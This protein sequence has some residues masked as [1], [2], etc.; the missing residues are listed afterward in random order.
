MYGLLGPNGAGKSI[1][2][3]SIAGDLSS[4]GLI[5][6]HGKALNLWSAK[7]KARHIAVLTQNHSL[8]FPFTAKEVVAF[9]LFPLTLSKKEADE[10]ITEYMHQTDTLSLEKRLYPSLSGGEQQ[11]IQ[12]ARVLL[13]LHQATKPP[14]LL[15]DEIT[16]A[17]DLGQQHQILSL[18]KSKTQQSA[19]TAIMI[20]HDIN[21][22]L[23]Y[24]NDCC[25]LQ[26]GRIY[27]TGKPSEVLSC[28]T[29]TNCWNYQPEQI[30]LA[31]GQIC[32]L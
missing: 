15:L 23:K 6:F 18:I 2:L 14:L 4:Q 19:L 12:L 32:L 9:G 21:Q 13:Q 29:V 30:T 31:N 11:R 1:L 27:D 22:T 28:E 5:S 3:R 8:T 16:S 24:C 25:V 20:L 10:V 26:N 17:Q 7:E